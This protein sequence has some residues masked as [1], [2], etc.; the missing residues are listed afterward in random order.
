M[1]ELMVARGL[2]MNPDSRRGYRQVVASL[3]SRTTFEANAIA[4]SIGF[5]WIVATV[6]L[7]IASRVRRQPVRARS[8]YCRDVLEAISKNG[9]EP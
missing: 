2:T 5:G 1:N 4:T 9:Q 3:E 8:G 7:Y 6:A